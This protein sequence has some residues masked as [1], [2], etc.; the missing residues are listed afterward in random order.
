[1][2]CVAFRLKMYLTL[3]CAVTYLQRKWF[4]LGEKKTESSL[5]PDWLDGAVS[6]VS[7]IGSTDNTA[8]A[9]HKWGIDNLGLS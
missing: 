1:M 6:R 4:I 7:V 8:Q 5:L 2:Q 3:L 9:R